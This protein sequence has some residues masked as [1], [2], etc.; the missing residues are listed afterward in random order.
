MLNALNLTVVS[1]KRVRIMSF[2]IHGLKPKTT[3]LLT[4]KQVKTL[5][6]DCNIA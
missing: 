3:H 1:L 5:L 4:D 2:V 6:A